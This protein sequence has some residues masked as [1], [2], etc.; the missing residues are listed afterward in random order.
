ME[1]I[2][3][4]LLEI[5]KGMEILRL[6]NTKLIHSSQSPDGNTLDLLSLIPSEI[7]II[8]IGYLEK[9]SMKFLLSAK[10]LKIP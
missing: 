4:Y 3:K 5:A 6:S 1:I 7:W 8:I 9:S 2:P 10:P